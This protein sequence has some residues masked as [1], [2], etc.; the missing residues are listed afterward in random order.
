MH[1]FEPTPQSILAVAAANVLIYSGVGLE[2][3]IPQIVAA[4][5]NP[6]LIVVDSS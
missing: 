4:A 1:D 2:P 3:W 6:E 5:N